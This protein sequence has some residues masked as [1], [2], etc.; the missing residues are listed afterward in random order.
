MDEG[1]K[2]RHHRRVSLADDGSRLEDLRGLLRH[3][4]QDGALAG[5]LADV[6][7]LLSAWQCGDIHAGAVAADALDQLEGLLPDLVRTLE[8]LSG[9]LPVVLKEMPP[10]PQ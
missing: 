7:E 4:A 8:G 5:R 9:L 1:L 10:A 3:L 2:T 6:D